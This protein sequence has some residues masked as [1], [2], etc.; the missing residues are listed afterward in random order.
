MPASDP[1]IS[2]DSFLTFGDL[3]KYLRK[4]A[5]LTQREL[6]IAVGYS[7]AQISRLEQNQRPPDLAALTA[8]FIPALYLEEEPEIVARLMEL[9]AQ[10]RGEI[11]PPSGMV[12]FSRSVQREIRENVRTVEEAGLNNLPLQLT[13]FIG[14]ER[15]IAEIRNF[16]ERPDGKARLVTL[17]GSG[18][19]GK[20][21]LALEAAKRITGE[22]P[23]GVWLIEL[24][25]VTDPAFVLQTIA[26]TL[27]LSETRDGST[28]DAV[29]KFLQPKRILLILDNCE[30][31]VSVIA[32][33]AEKILQA[34]LH[35]QILATSREILNVPG[36]MRYR[37]PSLTLPE[38]KSLNVDSATQFESLALFVERAQ[39][40]HPS[41]VYDR[42]NASAVARIC[43]RL[44]GIPLAIELA[45]ARM[46]TLSVGQI[47]ER[48]ENS[49]HL[50]SGGRKSLPRQETLQAAIEWSYEL[51]SG[52]ERVLLQ[53]LSV[54]SGG[55]TLEAAESVA[56]DPSSI[57]VEKILDL[58]SQLVNKSLVIAGWQSGA[59]TR[60]SM[61]ESVLEY[62]REKLALA[63]EREWARRRHFDYFSSVARQARLF[64]DEKGKWLDRFEADHENLRSALAWSLE[65][66]D[67][68]KG[69]G[70][71]L[72]ILDFYWFRGYSGEALEWMNKFLQIE[73]PPSQQQAMLLQKAG[74]LTRASGNFEAAELLLK[75]ALDMALGIGDK[76]RAAWA[77]GDL[78]VSARDQGHSQQAI[79][80]L[81][82]GLVYARESGETRA[83]GVHLYNLAQSYDLA[84]DHNSSRKLWIQG[85]DLFRREADKT[86]IAWGLEGLAGTSFLAKDFAAALELHLES[87]KI[88]MEVLDKLGIAYSF[89]GLAQVSAAGKEPIRAAVLWGAANLLRESMNVILESSREEI[90]TSLI[91]IVRD[92]LGNE[93]F[94]KAWEKGRSMKL[95]EAIDYAMN[96]QRD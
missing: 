72:P 66:G 86:H 50:L 57:A 38:D 73:S 82:E 78:G 65:K 77:L 25:P 49:F 45:A 80:Y 69:A 79:S 1:A 90:Y 30:Q 61:L 6:C 53:R 60:Y 4:R 83:I 47:A 51:L 10:A 39:A 12:T 44:D 13:S 93:G 43:L 87:L 64:G 17:T 7:E 56:G 3:L 24:A 68:E 22:Y 27:G 28:L 92:Q 32:R 89:E 31:I 58:L 37:V 67:M 26:S 23:E 8:L 16:L 88:K 95:P 59:E 48:L 34:C 54:F 84:G 11:L 40:V 91:P 29:I 70:L 81:S 85:L 96:R 55:W 19:S 9:A 52:D 5:Q 62:A 36:E 41:F 46:T 14:R 33:L 94:D 35:V 74:W 75:R 20:T 21:R 18:G 63:G 15:E 42:D 76:N 2:L 71:I